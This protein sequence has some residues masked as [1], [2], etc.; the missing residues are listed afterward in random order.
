MLGKLFKDKSMLLGILKPLLPRLEG[1]LNSQELEEG[2][3][4]K[5][6]MDV[7]NNEISI[8]IVAIKK[9]ENGHFEITKVLQD[10]NPTEL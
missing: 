5:I 4:T 9:M 8:Q 7:I 2:E 1:F 3:K 10:I 6:L